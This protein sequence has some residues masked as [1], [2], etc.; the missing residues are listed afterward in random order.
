M[1]KKT[2]I[3]LGN[4]G[5]HM[6]RNIMKA[7][8]ALHGFDISKRALDEFAEAGGTAASSAKEA[9]SGADLLMLMV[10]TG[11]QA[12]AALFSTGVAESLEKGS[13]V[14]LCSTISP[15]DAR[16]IANELEVRGH[17]MLDAPVSGGQ[18]GAKAGSLT[19]M[20]SGPSEARKKAWPI[21]E[22]I[23][24]KIY[25]LGESAGLGAT[26]K[27]VHQLAAGVHL[28]AAAELMSFGEKAGCD[29]K[30][31]LEI[32]SAS[33]GRSWMLQ[34]RGP[35][36]LQD[37]PKATST[38]DIFIKDMGLVLETGND[39]AVALPMARTARQMLAKARDLG[40]G[41]SDDS[42]VV[43]VYESLTDVSS[44]ANSVKSSDSECLP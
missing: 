9:A 13:T 28:V 21:L 33:A 27:V 16:E 7:G 23:S 36:M 39:C 30:T 25:V 15:M 5:G 32:V 37:D 2:F 38:V 1:S 44:S 40:L 29:P 35:R 14:V 10:E 20:V 4:M 6:A 3:G 26:Y 42:Q 43:R 19:A 17:M 41:A 11:D 22:A 34:D 18:A 12:R 8:M 31:L 24:G